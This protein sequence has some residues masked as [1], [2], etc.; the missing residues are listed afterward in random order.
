MLPE[1]IVDLQMSDYLM[2]AF[3]AGV[4]FFAIDYGGFTGWWRHPV[5]WIL[6]GFPIS[7]G[8]ILALLVYGVVFGQRVDE[9]VRVPVMGFALVLIVGKIIALHISRNEGKIARRKE[10][11]FMADLDSSAIPTEG[12]PMTIKTDDGTPVVVP[13]IWYQGQRVLRSILTTALTVLPLIPQVI[14]IIQGQWQAEWL[15][16]VAVQAV[17]INAALTKIIALPTVNTWLTSI[18][19]GSVPKKSLEAQ[20]V[21]DGKGA[22]VQVITTVKPDP[23][24]EEAFNPVG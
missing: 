10:Q 4:L 3:I 22:E 8:L 6:L 12:N 14:A 1:W 21:S 11:P 18:G 17:A 20:V 15:T 13:R 5:G 24:V 23:K 19:L 2:F 9:W 16:A 7:M